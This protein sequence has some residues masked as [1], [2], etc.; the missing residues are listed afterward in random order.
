MK[1]LS[2]GYY[3]CFIGQDIEAEK[4]E[5]PMVSQRVRTKTQFQIPRDHLLIYSASTYGT[6]AG[7]QALCWFMVLALEEFGVQRTERLA[8]L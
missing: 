5:L 4:T 7:F 3:L 8:S 6:P 2:Q 1:C